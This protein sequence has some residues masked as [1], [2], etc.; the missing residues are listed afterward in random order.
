MGRMVLMLIIDMILWPVHHLMILHI[1]SFKLLGEQKKLRLHI[2]IMSPEVYSNWVDVYLRFCTWVMIEKKINLTL[3]NGSCAHCLVG[4]KGQAYMDIVIKGPLHVDMSL[5]KFAEEHLS[6]AKWEGPASYRL[7]LNGSSVS[8]V[9]SSGWK[10]KS[11]MYTP[12][13]S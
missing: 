10:R 2:A 3:R 7:A 8:S 4:G 5:R 9:F 1:I 12:K 6:F 11:S 13:R